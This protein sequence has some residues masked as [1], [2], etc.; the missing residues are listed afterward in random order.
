MPNRRAT[1]TQADVARVI[2]AAKQA[3]ASTVD[4]PVGDKLITVHLEP[5]TAPVVPLAESEEI[6]L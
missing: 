3:G 6:V 2:R 1:I 5:S 4:V